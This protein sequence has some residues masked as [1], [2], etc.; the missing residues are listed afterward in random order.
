MPHEVRARRL[1]RPGH[2]VHGARGKTHFGGELGEP[3]C[4][5]RSGRIRLQHHCATGCERRRELPRGHHQRVIPR[6]D[7]ARYA[8]RLFQ[9]VEEEGAA[10]R[11]RAARNRR[12]GRPVEAAVLDAL[13]ELGLH[14]G[15]R[16][17]DVANLELRE[18]LAIGDHRVGQRVQQAGTLRGR[19]FGPRA[20]E[21]RAGRLDRKIDVRL[22]GHGNARERLAGGRLRQVAQLTGLR[23]DELAVDEEPVFMPRRDGHRRG[24]YGFSCG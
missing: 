15:D 19:R 1:P 6:D 18:L 21:R 7:L 17:A 11:V 12:D 14:G 22:A 2:D 4:R 20:C 24:G 23:L 16:L 3:Q 9:R 13:V 5:Q 10:E 8:D